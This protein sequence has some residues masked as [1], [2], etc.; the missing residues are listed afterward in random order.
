[1]FRQFCTCPIHLNLGM[2]ACL[3]ESPDA[4]EII[5]HA[6]I[7]IPIE[8]QAKTYPSL[9]ATLYPTTVSSMALPGQSTRTGLFINISN[10]CS[11]TGSCEQWEHTPPTTVPFL[12]PA[13]LDDQVELGLLRS[14]SSA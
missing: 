8:E 12:N 6:I 10:S 1:M 4:R 2:H 5:G 14:S 13:C 11:S 7:Y 9:K 3:P